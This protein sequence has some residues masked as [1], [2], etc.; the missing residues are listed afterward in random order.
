MTA[1]DGRPPEAARIVVSLAAGPPDVPGV[2]GV[3]PVTALVTIPA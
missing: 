3:R 1:D 2:T